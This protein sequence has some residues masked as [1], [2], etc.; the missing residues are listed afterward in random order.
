MGNVHCQLLGR[1]GNPL[2]NYPFSKICM[3]VLSEGLTNGS[4]NCC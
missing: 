2:Y 1:H 4:L 3:G